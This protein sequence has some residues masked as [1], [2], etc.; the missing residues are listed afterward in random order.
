[1]SYT[2]T[3]VRPVRHSSTTAETAASASQDCGESQSMSELPA[4]SGSDGSSCSL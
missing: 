4:T 1:M 2:G 3:S